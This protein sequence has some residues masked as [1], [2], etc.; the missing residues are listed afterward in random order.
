MNKRE[1]SKAQ[2]VIDAVRHGEA[3]GQPLQ[4]VFPVKETAQVAPEP[5]QTAQA[6]GGIPGGYADICGA[7]MCPVAGGGHLFCNA[8]PGHEGRHS[9]TITILHPDAREVVRASEPPL[10]E[11][12]QRIGRIVQD[13]ITALLAEHGLKHSGGHKTAEVVTRMVEM[14]GER[15][16]RAAWEQGRDAAADYMI[17]CAERWVESLPIDEV[18]SLNC[19]QAAKGIKLLTP[20]GVEPEKRIDTEHCDMCHE[21]VKGSV[22]YELV[23]GRHRCLKCM[24]ALDAPQDLSGSNQGQSQAGVEPGAKEGR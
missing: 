16:A 4:A 8:K 17:R 22:H 5:P 2:K 9:H 7:Q 18:A 23:S 11:E 1:I 12:A 20:P 15:V 13:E 24:K 21:P 6:C 14:Y 10:P 19:R 3:L